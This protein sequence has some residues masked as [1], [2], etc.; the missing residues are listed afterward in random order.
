[1]PSTVNSYFQ[2]LRKGCKNGKRQFTGSYAA[3]NV[4]TVET[5]SQG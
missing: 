3:T 5:L 2:S 4:E 1:M